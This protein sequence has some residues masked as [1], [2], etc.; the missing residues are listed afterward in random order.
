MKLPN[1]KC[2]LE[3][4]HNKHRDYYQTA[5][6]AIAERESHGCPPDWKDEEAK[7]RAIA[8]DE[9]WELHWY[10]DTPIGFHAIY[11]PT[12]EELLAFAAD[13]DLANAA[14]QTAAPK[15]YQPKS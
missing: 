4:T 5:A 7:Q 14:G 1:H 15:T 11:A 8:T 13:F 12:L 6:E 3:L 10:P 2:S 9:I